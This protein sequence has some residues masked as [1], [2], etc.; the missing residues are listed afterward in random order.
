[1]RKTILDGPRGSIAKFVEY[2]CPAPGGSNV[3][4][5]KQGKVAGNTMSETTENQEDNDD[6]LKEQGAGR[7]KP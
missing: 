2:L 4:G 5:S 7:D 1:M 6:H 3:E